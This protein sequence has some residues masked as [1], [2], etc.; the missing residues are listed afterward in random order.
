MS[1]TTARLHDRYPELGTGPV[2]V[3]PYISP[4]YFAQEKEKIF[5]KTWLQVGR[6]EEIPGVGDYFVKELAACDTSI[7]V[8]RNKQGVIR[9]MHNVCAHRMNQVVYEPCGKARKFFC[10]FTAGPMTWTAS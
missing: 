10:K 7:I 6:V 3:E 9:A 2:P 8:V 4:A 1:Q 5:K